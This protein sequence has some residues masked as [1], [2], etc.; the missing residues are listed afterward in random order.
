MPVLSQLVAPFKPVPP[1]CSARPAGSSSSRGKFVDD[2]HVRLRDFVR[3]CIQRTPADLRRHL[4]A[5]L[6]DGGF[7]SFG[8]MCSGTESPLLVVSA[9]Q[10][11]FAEE[12]E[13][14]WR[15]EHEFSSDSSK[16]VQRFIDTMFSP[17]ALY[18]DCTTMA[19]D[20]AP[21]DAR[22]GLP[23]PVKSVKGLLA[24]FPC[25][26]VSRL[27]NNATERRLA[28]MDGKLR[29]GHVFKDGV[30][31]YCKK[32]E[33]FIE[34]CVTE[35]VLG[36][37]DRAPNGISPLQWVAALWQ[38]ADFFFK[39]FE[40]DPSAF[41]FMI[42]RPRLWMLALPLRLLHGAEMSS[43]D[44]EAFLEK[45]MMWC[46]GAGAQEPVRVGD[47]MLDADHASV[48]KYQRACEALPALKYARPTKRAR[49]TPWAEAHARICDARGVQSWWESALP[50]ASEQSMWP[51]LKMIRPRE[52]DI[53]KFSFGVTYP[54]RIRRL[55]QI[56]P[57]MGRNLCRVD[58]CHT[59][60]RTMRAFDTS[61]VRMVLGIEAM[62]M[63]GLHYGPKHD[64]LQALD[65]GHL[66]SLAGNAF[67]S[68]CC[69]ATVYCGLLLLAELR[70]RT[71]SGYEGSSEPC[72]RADAS[73]QAAQASSMSAAAEDCP[74]PPPW[75]GDLDF[76]DAVF[77]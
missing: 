18:G 44:A 74:A 55:I 19:S 15:P 40:L 70:A 54:E 62:M 66:M 60:N 46:T 2:G 57:S 14:D 29:T 31:A 68:W 30:L 69:A 27:V 5:Y 39:A 17:P 6:Q 41:G 25:P 53:L 3:R 33:D 65:D 73:R 24:G 49:S 1:A 76:L 13:L 28:V 59:I 38:E 72:A 9:M 50:T 64:L 7:S 63:Q 8:T 67:H 37:A 42:D 56:G 36:L 26:D 51:T 32:F 61:L 77:G 75:R 23:V 45:C 43:Q 16:F 21:V 71:Q 52:F 20:R 22:T 58:G 48:V 35:N 4:R 47:L 10:V 12:L 11:A 34:M